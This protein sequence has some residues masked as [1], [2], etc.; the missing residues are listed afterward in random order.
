MNLIMFGN[1]IGIFAGIVLLWW[2]GDKA[3]KFSEEMAHVFGLSTFFVGFIIMSVSTGFPELAVSI[4]SILKGVGS[5]S[6]GDI[7]GSN[8]SD[9]AL[10]L[11]IPAFFAGSIHILKSEYDNFVFMLL[12]TS[13][14]MSSVFIIGSLTAVHGVLLIGLYVYCLLILWKA[15]HVKKIVKEKAELSKE[16]VKKLVVVSKPW[17][18][19]KLVFSLVGL[20]A[21]SELAV[22]NAIALAE[23]FNLSLSTLGATI[24]AVGTS[25]PEL[26]VSMSAMKRKDYSLMLGNSLGSVLEQATL[27]LGF[28]AIAAPSPVH[29][30]YL[31]SIAPFMFLAFGIIGFGIIKRRKINR[32]EGGLLILLYVAY[33][34]YN[35]W[36]KLY[37]NSQLG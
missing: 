14:V 4:T 9:L 19:L 2:A 3:V 15:R 8:F 29:L 32:F 35:Y 26:S 20:L 25:L 28:L 27:I 5:L 22:R 33:I 18:I 21:A 10:V 11:G 6:A 24:F 31:R 17:I 7:I 34:G 13:L 36:G 23:V 37:L 12:I 1:F 30:Q 16:R